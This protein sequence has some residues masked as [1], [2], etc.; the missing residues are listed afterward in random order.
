M[1][2]RSASWGTS[3][4]TE[5]SSLPQT[6]TCY[7]VF[8]ASPSGLEKER[9]AFKEELEEFNLRDG[10]SRGVVFTPVGWEDTLGGIGRPQSLI[11]EELRR[12]DY[13]IMVLHDRWGSDPGGDS[14]HTSG[15]H[16]E[17]HEALACHAKGEMRALA[18][19]F[20][21]VDER[22]MADPGPQLSKVLEFKRE[23]EASRAHL[24]NSYDSVDRYRS[25]VRGHLSRWIRDHESG[26]LGPAERLIQ[27]SGVTVGVLDGGSGVAEDSAIARAWALAN[28]GR[29]TEA[30]VEFATASV[31]Q[32][33]T[34]PLIE[35][36]MY[37][38]RVG[39]LDRAEVM[40]RRTT[41]LADER[42]DEALL[43]V[44]YGNLGS[45]LR[46]RGDLDGAEEMYRKALKIAEKLG[47][48]PMIEQVR[49]LTESMRG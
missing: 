32:S 28:E 34:A 24:F 27:G 8:I 46:T 35:Y 29:H 1:S 30:E 38:F 10:M 43:S 9:K 39:Q 31:G 40:F 2:T 42:G 19:L 12:C 25:L 7:R 37:L 41:E 48:E 45:V 36:G 3:N 44:G 14:E 17:Y 21:G 47:A 5:E 15:T 16:E 4:Y 18:M 22:Q 23:I 11:N 13:F 26:E 20:K 6:L 49:R 33:S